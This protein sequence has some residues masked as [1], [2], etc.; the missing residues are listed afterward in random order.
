MLTASVSDVD[1]S[2]PVHEGPVD[3]EVAVGLGYG[4]SKWVSEQILS[5]AA[6]KTTL[7]AVSVRV[8]QVAG[9]PK[10]AWKTSEWFPL[11][12]KSSIYLRCFPSLDKVRPPVYFMTSILRLA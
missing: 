6:Q 5:I 11:L 12:V 2:K 10:G 1:P 3:P 7:R 4:E 9:G 8:G